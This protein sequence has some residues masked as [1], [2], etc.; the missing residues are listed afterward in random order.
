M[1]SA[2]GEKPYCRFCNSCELNFATR[3]SCRIIPETSPFLPSKKAQQGSLAE[4][5]LS[6][7]IKRPIGRHRSVRTVRSIQIF[8]SVRFKFV[9]G[10][11]KSAKNKNGGDEI[12]KTARP[13]LHTLPLQIPH[14]LGFRKPGVE[15]VSSSWFLLQRHP[16][17]NANASHGEATYSQVVTCPLTEGV[18]HYDAWYK[19]QRGSK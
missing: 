3:K 5:V 17:G 8:R 10:N 2:T 6:L 16:G 1:D 18:R 15:W 14:F 9:T 19:V 13:F 4:I 11:R 12:Q 7:Q